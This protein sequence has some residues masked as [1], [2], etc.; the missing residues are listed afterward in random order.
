MP[1]VL[2]SVNIKLF[3]VAIGKF[4]SNLSVVSLNNIFAS[5]ALPLSITNPPELRVI[6]ALLSPLFILIILSLT[7]SSVVFTVV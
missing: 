1:E 4:T 6:P 2:S 3:S 7:L 5:V